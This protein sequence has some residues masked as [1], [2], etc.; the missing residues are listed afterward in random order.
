L[1]CFLIS[2]SSPFIIFDL[3]FIF[4]Y[5][6]SFW[7]VSFDITDVF[8]WNTST[9]NWCSWLVTIR[10]Y[11]E[12]KFIAHDTDLSRSR[13]LNLSSLRLLRTGSRKSWAVI[14]GEGWICRF[15]SCLWSHLF[16]QLMVRHNYCLKKKMHRINQRIRRNKNDLPTSL[17]AQW[18]CC[19]LPLLIGHN[20]YF[21]WISCDEI[22]AAWKNWKWKDMFIC[23][24]LISNNNNLLF[25]IVVAFSYF[26]LH[27]NVI[28]FFSCICSVIEW[29]Y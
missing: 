2:N 5:Y 9:N 17:D 15:I 16:S 28:L 18:N 4:I 7:F 11:Y 24:P 8:T 23:L 22:T 19:I 26:I 27:A 10:S 25:K 1:L 21:H 20:A 29:M 14:W 6:C 13:L 12:C 3:Q